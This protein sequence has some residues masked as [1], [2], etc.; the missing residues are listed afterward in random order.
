MNSAGDK[1]MTAASEA[2]H[3]DYLDSAVDMMTA[4][5]TN[6]AGVVLARTQDEMMKSTLD[7]LA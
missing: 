3:E 6:K 2:S 1:M 4:R 7:M 5:N